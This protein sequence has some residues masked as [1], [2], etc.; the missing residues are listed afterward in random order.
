M[1]Q[2]GENFL[3]ILIDKGTVG[4]ALLLGALFFSFLIESSKAVSKVNFE[5]STYLA[6]SN[7][8]HVFAGDT[9][10]KVNFSKEK[11]DR[12]DRLQRNSL[13][14]KSL[15]SVS[16]GIALV[17]S[18]LA[19]FVSYLLKMITFMISALVIF[20]RMIAP[21]RAGPPNCFLF[22][23]PPALA[24]D[25]PPYSIPYFNKTSRSSKLILNL[26]VTNLFNK[27]SHNVRVL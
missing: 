21:N 11:K 17:L 10:S 4:V 18:Y 13:G 24:N 12:V 6:S 15:D 8:A 23:I 9:F 16:E 25:C 5:S 3:N 20:M 1:R 7:L 22:S 26:Y 14:A 19:I 2:F 27:N